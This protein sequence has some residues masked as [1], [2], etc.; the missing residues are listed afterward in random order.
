LLYVPRVSKG[1]TVGQFSVRFWGVRG[2]IATSGCEYTEVGGHTSCVEV[3]AGN[4]TI[5]LDAGTG[6]FPLSQTL[7]EPTTA[8]FFLSHFHWDH[9]QG[10]PLFRPAYAPGNA[11]L[12]YGPAGAEAALRQQMQTPHFPVAL[13]EMRARLTF[14]TVAP[15]DEVRVG[16][17]RVR[18][19]AL[20]HPQGCLGYRISFGGMTVVYATDTEHIAPGIAD[21]GTLQLAHGADLLIYDAQYT[22]EEYHGNGCPG[23]LGW[24]HSTISGA[25]Q[26]ARAAG[27]RQLALFHH[28]PMH[29]DRTIARLTEQASELFPEVFAARE[30]LTVHLLQSDEQA[31]DAAWAAPRA[32]ADLGPPEDRLAAAGEMLDDVEARGFPS[33]L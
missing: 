30:G 14:R 33:D 21:P 18:V 16:A 9:I 7:R 15:E 26:I 1:A 10:F 11:F 19:A 29:D 22:D 20:N 12:I 32:H 24:G 8:T 17:A 3:R 25:C 28:D 23:R 5:I 6:L 31:D 27:V 2:S 4:E 13:A